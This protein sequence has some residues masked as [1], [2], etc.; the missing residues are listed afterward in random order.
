MLHQKIQRWC[1]FPKKSILK[2]SF[3]AGYEL[4]LVCRR[5]NEFL[6]VELLQDY[7]KQIRKVLS[8]DEIVLLPEEFNSS[9]ESYLKISKSDQ[10]SINYNKIR[11][12]LLS[13]LITVLFLTGVIDKYFDLNSLYQKCL[14]RKNGYLNYLL[15]SVIGFDKCI[16]MTS[17]WDVSKYFLWR[18]FLID[19]NLRQHI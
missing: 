11:Y 14:D 19:F 16:K 15:N 7:K 3:Q 5:I 9:V 8:E 13:L 12:Y 17:A 18:L 4:A 2:F 10:I 1:L 6:E